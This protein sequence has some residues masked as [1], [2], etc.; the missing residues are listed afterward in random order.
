M[1]VP[2]LDRDTLQLLFTYLPANDIASSAQFVCKWWHAAAS[3]QNRVTKCITECLVALQTSRFEERKAHTSVFKKLDET[4]EE[5]TLYGHFLQGW[6]FA[7]FKES[8]GVHEWTTTVRLGEAI[9]IYDEPRLGFSFSPDT[10]VDT[11][12]RY[13]KPITHLS[14]TC[15][16]ALTLAANLSLKN[17]HHIALLSITKANSEESTFYQ[18]VVDN[19]WRQTTTFISQLF[20]SSSRKEE[21]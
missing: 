1:N 5:V 6:Q 9:A 4:Q 19:V 11:Q 2:S 12:Y 3:I 21:S 7:I 18:Y 17:A 15:S 16:Q 8:K 10:N 20:S 14:V 13:K